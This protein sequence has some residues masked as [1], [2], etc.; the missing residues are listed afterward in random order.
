MILGGKDVYLIK[1]RG[2]LGERAVV[3]IDDLEFIILEY[4]KENDKFICHVYEDANDDKEPAASVTI[5][6]YKY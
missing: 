5:E 3:Y 4:D 6:P 1:E 2:S